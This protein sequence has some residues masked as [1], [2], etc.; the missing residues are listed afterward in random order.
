MYAVGNSIILIK[1]YPE[2]ALSILDFNTI[3]AGRWALFHGIFYVCPLFD[4]RLPVYV[5][6]WVH[7]DLTLEWVVLNNF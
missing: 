2:A 5:S 3:N 4:I 7:L 1:S 6:I